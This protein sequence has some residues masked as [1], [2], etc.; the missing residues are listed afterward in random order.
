MKDF[1]APQLSEVT[2]RRDEKAGVALATLSNLTVPELL[3]RR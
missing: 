2:D 3:R 1:G